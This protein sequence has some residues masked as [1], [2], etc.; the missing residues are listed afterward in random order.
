MSDTLP[1]YDELSQ[2]FGCTINYFEWSAP[3]CNPQS[4][5]SR[6]SLRYFHTGIDIPAPPGTP[7]YASRSGTVCGIGTEFL[8]PNAV[9]LDIGGDITLIYGHLNESDVNIGESVAVGTLLGKVGNLGASRGPHLHFAA[10]KQGFIEAAGTPEQRAM[11]IDPKLY[12]NV[13]HPAILNHNPSE[14]EDMVYYLTP[15]APNAYF[16][17][18]FAGTP[19][20]YMARDVWVAVAGDTALTGGQ[21]HI[22]NVRVYF[23]P[24]DPS[25]AVSQDIQVNGSTE[26][27]IKSPVGGEQHVRVELLSMPDGSQSAP[28]IVRV[29]QEFLKG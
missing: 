2:D 18:A 8:G 19:G 15:A 1:N 12:L 28:V 10:S 20:D 9:G 26:T 3:D 24:A 23:V 16:P 13:I 22:A 14:D 6:D 29:Y 27:S 11:Y 17:G 7:V 25:G 5:E 21:D 4:I